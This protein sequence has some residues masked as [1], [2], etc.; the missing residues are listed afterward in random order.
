MA[1]SPIRMPENRHGLIVDVRTTHATGRAERKIAEAM[2]AGPAR[3]RRIT[4]GSDKAYDAREHVAPLHTMRVIPH[5]AQ[6]RSNR[7]SAIDG[8]PTRDTDHAIGQPIRKRIDAPFDRIKAAVGLIVTP[9][10][11]TASPIRQIGQSGSHVADF[12]NPSFLPPAPKNFYS[13]LSLI[14][15]AF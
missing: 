10:T 4:V 15:C 5:V 12:L 6:N 1:R 9:T 14:P 13:L 8:R 11:A 7:R 2:V 3:G